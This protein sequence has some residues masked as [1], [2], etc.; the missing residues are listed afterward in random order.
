MLDTRNVRL[1]TSRR[2]S[3]TA[4]DAIEKE[5]QRKFLVQIKKS[6]ILAAAQILHSTNL[7]SRRQSLGNPAQQNISFGTKG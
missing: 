4:T 7:E 6:R 2:P 5:R 1:D 3:L